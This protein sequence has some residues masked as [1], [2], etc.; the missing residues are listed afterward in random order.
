M[1]KDKA[2]LGFSDTEVGL[3]ATFYLVGAVIGALGFGYLTLFTVTLLLYLAAMASAW[4]L[5][6]G[7]AVI[8]IKAEGQSL[9]AV[10]RPLTAR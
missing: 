3:T 1:L 2:S 6:T 10:T 4:N 8:G 5:C 7:T 9:E